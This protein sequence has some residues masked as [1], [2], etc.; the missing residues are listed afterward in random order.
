VKRIF[1]GY[2]AGYLKWMWGGA[3]PQDYAWDAYPDKAEEVSVMPATHANGNVG[4]S[5]QNGVQPDYDEYHLTY[6]RTEG[7]GLHFTEQL[8]RILDIDPE[9]MF[10]TGWNEW[11]ASWWLNT[12]GWTWLKFLGETVPTDGFYYVDAYNAE[13]NRDIEPM[14]GGYTDNYYYQMIDGIR[15]FKGVRGPQ[16]ASDPRT[17][18]IDG[19]F[20]DWSDVKPEFRDTIGDTFHRNHDG[21]GSAGPYINT[22]GRNDLMDMKVARDDDHI[23]FYAKTRD[24]ITAYT[25]PAWMQLYL[26]TDQDYNTGWEGYDYVINQAAYN[27]TRTT[28][29]LTDS[30]IAADL[31]GFWKLDEMQGERAMDSSGSGTSGSLTNGPLWQGED[32]RIDGAL[33]FDGSD[34]HVNIDSVID[35]INTTSGAITCWIRF[36]PS[37][38]GDSL[39]HGIVEIGNTTANDY[40]IALRKIGD[41]TIRLRYRSGA[42]NYDATITDISDFA[43]WH[44]IAAVWTD[45]QVKI[46]LDGSHQ[47]TQPRGSDISGA[48]DF[49]RLGRTAQGTFAT[50][51]KGLLDDV[52]IYSTALDGTAVATLAA[53]T[54][55]IT[56]NSNISYAA[57]GN[58]IEIKVPRSDLG[59]GSSDDDIA[60]DL[61]WA[62]NIQHY[63]DIIEFALSGDSAPNRR[64]NYRYDTTVSDEACQR[65][66]DDGNGNNMDLDA[67]CDLDVYDLALFAEDWLTPHDL[68]SFANLAEDWLLD[69]LPDDLDA[70]ILLE[71]DFEAALGNWITGWVQT[72]SQF[73]SPS[74]SLW[75]Q[76]CINDVVSTD[77]DASGKN[78]IHI[79]FKYKMGNGCD[80]YDNVFLQYYN[81]SGYNTIVELSENDSDVW[82]YYSD[83]IYN[84]GGDA[85]YFINNFRIKLDGSGINVGGEYFCI[86]DVMIF[87]E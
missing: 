86:D 62:D 19:N 68:D 33:E 23:Y 14:K 85:Q 37:F 48:L 39:T 63:N 41:E 56:V 42:A 51:F 77:L 31:L 84:A 83:T 40:A 7:Q 15:K 22:T 13:Y 4:K 38:I 25:D 57:S 43:N 16:T 60:I 21:F 45:T 24:D 73:F 27:A 8:Q 28:L 1:S 32:G 55:S 70:T 30:S 12:E 58:Q 69:Y 64:F 20:S 78:S 18:S 34:D 67:D 81:G 61:H 87:T 71:D 74:Q 80:S 11:T 53:Q 3:H 59:L 50:Y 9:F 47:D 49:A 2:E 52:R 35:N 26:N 29:R 66:F 76:D 44:H 72:T 17:I 54:D 5:Y 82:L 6:A 79:S 36:D 46:Y 65:I 10:I 75:C